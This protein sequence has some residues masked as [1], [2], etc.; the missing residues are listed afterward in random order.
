MNYYSA[1]DRGREGFLCDYAEVPP[2]DNVN[3]CFPSGT[4]LDWGNR[5]YDV[6]L[7]VADK[8]WDPIAG[9]MN[10]AVLNDDGFL[11]DR[12]TVNFLYKPYLDVRARRYR[13]RI[14]NGAVARFMKIALV[15]R[16]GRRGHRH[17]PRSGRLGRV[18]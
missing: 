9:Q 2:A 6:N 13:L 7:V 1:I 16:G 10:M 5:D 17:V 11:A 4:A 18:L 8:A 15:G 12:M 14:L 3:L